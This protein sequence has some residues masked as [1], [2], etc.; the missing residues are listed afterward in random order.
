MKIQKKLLTFLYKALKI[1]FGKVFF[2]AVAAILQITWVAFFMYAMG[3]RYPF[4]AGAVRLV[5]FLVMLNILNKPTNPSFKLG[6][7][8]IMLPAPVVGFAIYITLGRSRLTRK[9]ADRCDEVTRET[10]HL[11]IEN[12]EYREALEQES[13]LAANQ[14]LYL[15]RCAGYPVWQRTTTRYYPSGEL[16]YKDMIETLENARHYIFM[17]YFIIDNGEMWNSILDILERKAKEGLDVRVIYD[18]MGCVNTLPARF[19]RDLRKRGIACEEFNPFRPFVT[20]LYNNRDHRKIM[21]VDG[22]T[23]FTG[24][25]NLADEYINRKK[26]FGYW[27]DTGIS[28]HGEAVWNFTVMFLQMWSVVTGRS[29]VFDQVMKFTPEI[30]HIEKFESDGFVQPYGDTPLDQETVGE[31]VYLNILGQAKKYVY[32]FTPYLVIDNEMI[33]RLCLTAKSG[34]DVRIVV[35]GIPD[36]RMVYLL[37][38]SYFEQLL[39]AGVRIYEYTPGF[40]HA[41]CFVCDDEIATVGTINMD[42]RSLYLH[43]ENGVWMYRSRAVGQVKQDVLDTIERSR[44]V[45]LEE[46][47]KRPIAVRL[48]QRLLRILA[49]LM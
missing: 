31:N 13:Q 28:L 30:H 47:K 44:E 18:G 29:D 37:T 24:G 7:A 10:A 38:T 19:C 32:M 22:H 34:V 48:Q 17:E 35:P 46:C 39:E 41:K 1:L 27:K 40:L 21:V 26:R 5:S 20:A 14:S 12:P 23:A 11:L 16:L 43:F 49:P 45:T 36:K 3:D 33:T 2:V 6:W 8:I 15:A 9:V 4:F 25:I 42:Y